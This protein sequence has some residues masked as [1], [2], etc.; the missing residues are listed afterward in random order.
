MNFKNMLLAAAVIFSLGTTVSAKR[1]VRLL[2]W[3]VQNGMWDGQTDDYL[4]FTD[5]VKQQQPDVCV[6]CEAVKLYITNTADREVENMNQD[7][8]RARDGQSR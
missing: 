3:N 5:W 6:W 1:N 7:G 4:R 2:Y 8:R